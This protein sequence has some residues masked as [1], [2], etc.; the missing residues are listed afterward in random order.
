[1]KPCKVNLK[2][3][4]VCITANN[5]KLSVFVV[6]LLFGYTRALLDTPR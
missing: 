5:G 4:P 6:R 3:I 1:M 2:M